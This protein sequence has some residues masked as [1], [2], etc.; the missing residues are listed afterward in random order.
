MMDS[1]ISLQF[2]I[3]GVEKRGLDLAD[4]IN[5]KATKW[6]Y[7]KCYREIEKM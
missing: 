1:G 7:V 3:D 4:E 2:I 5:G 6:F